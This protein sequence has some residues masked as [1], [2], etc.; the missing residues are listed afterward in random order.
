MA[1]HKT[2]KGHIFIL[3]SQK[4]FNFLSFQSS[5][6]NKWIDTSLFLQTHMKG[7]RHK[8]SESKL[9]ERELD[10]Q[11]EK[12]KRIALSDCSATVSSTTACGPRILSANKPLVQRARKAASEI[13]NGQ[14]PQGSTIQK[15][16]D[17]RSYTSARTTESPSVRD[18]GVSTEVGEVSSDIVRHQFEYLDRR[19]RELKFTAAGWKRDCHGKW[20]KDEN[21]RFGL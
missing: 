2:V 18:K 13:L 16:Q 1:I 19:E 15:I 8:A 17:V 3:M 10:I 21:V 4:N 12:N 14:S 20:F 11:N 6:V 7:S 5:I 9:R